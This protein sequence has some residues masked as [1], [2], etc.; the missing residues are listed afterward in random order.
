MFGGATRVLSEGIGT[1]DNCSVYFGCAEIISKSEYKQFLLPE[2]E[3]EILLKCMKGEYIFTDIA[4]TIIFGEAA[5][6]RKREINRFEYREYPVK[7]VSFQTFG[8][9]DLDCSLRI[10]L[11]SAARLDIDIKKNEQE[12]GIRVY[13]I[14]QAVA[15]V[16]ETEERNMKIAV[17]A[18]TASLGSSLTSDIAVMQN[19]ANIAINGAEMLTNRYTRRSYKDVFESSMRS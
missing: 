2:E 18:F 1:A 16:Q 3:P 13:R 17:S 12:S 6:G 9:G 19:L 10:V 14:L 11:G 7:N 8:V 15:N 5:A 4:L